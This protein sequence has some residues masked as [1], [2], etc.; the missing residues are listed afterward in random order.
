MLHNGSS[1]L[2]FNQTQMHCSRVKISNHTASIDSTMKFNLILVQVVGIYI[3]LKVLPIQKSLKENM[4]TYFH[5]NNCK[6]INNC[7]LFQYNCN[8]MGPS[9]QGSHKSWFTKNQGSQA[10]LVPNIASPCN[11]IDFRCIVA[12]RRKAI[13]QEVDFFEALSFFSFFIFFILVCT[14]KI[15]RM[16]AQELSKKQGRDCFQVW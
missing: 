8:I 2:Q 14:F 9:S 7:N 11:T 12:V 16:L 10:C 13:C 6:V 15:I 5:M 3:L 4:T 1:K